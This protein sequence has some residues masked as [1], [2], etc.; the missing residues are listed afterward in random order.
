MKQIFKYITVF[1][2]SLTIVGC[3][4]KTELPS[5]YTSYVD[6]T[7][8]SDYHG[9]VFVGASVPFGMVQ[10]GPTNISKG[11]DWCSGYHRSDSVII[12]FA[13]THLSGTG[14]GDL[15]DIL[16]MPSPD[17]LSTQKA[18]YATTYS[19]DNQS[20]KP[21]YYSVAL[22]NG[23]DVELTSTNRVGMHRYQFPEGSQ[24]RLVFDLGEGIDWDAPTDTYIK[25]IDETTI[26]GHRFSTGWAKDQKIY[27]TASFSA[28]IKAFTPRK[29]WCYRPRTKD[30]I[31]V[32][33]AIVDFGSTAEL[34]AKVALSYVS[35]DNA[36]ENMSA[37]LPEW[38]FD[39]VVAAADE[40]WE[41]QLSKIDA[42]SS[43]PAV[44]RTFYTALY[45]TMISPVT[46]CDVNGDY[47]GADGKSYNTQEFTPYSIFSLWDT[48]RT[49]SPLSMILHPDKIEDYVNS[50]LAIYE[51]Q[52]KLPVW[53]LVGNETDCMVG[54]HSVPVIVDA[55]LKGYR[56]FDA[57]LAFE[58][59][60]SFAESDERGLKYV[61]EI[62]Y[63]PAEKEGWSVAKALEYAID[64]YAIAQ[65]ARALGRDDDYKRYTERSKYY[66]NYF[67][68]SVGFMRGK[69][70]NGEWNPKFDPF[71]SMHMEDDYVE[72]NAWQYT[73]LVPHDVQGLVSLFD[74]EESFTQKLDSL[75]TVSS[76][77][78]EGASVDITGLIGQ[79]AHGNEPSH[80]TLYLYP[81]V[82]QQWKSAP[83]L[84][85]V[86][87]EFY[88]DTP[89][90]IVGN[91]DCG[92]MSAWYIMSVMGI[93]PVNPVGGLYVFGSPL[94]QEARINLEGGKCFEMVAHDLSDDAI[95]IQSVRL[96]GEP[97]TKSYITHDDLMR[98]AKL[99]F[100]MGAEPNQSFASEVQ[101]RPLQQYL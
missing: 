48:Y 36:K 64:D 44:M 76:E 45:H 52:G 61:N 93:Y 46:F 47:R 50:F 91:E 62:G 99:E 59:M 70:S 94:L 90:G 51:Q 14:I 6:P 7:I 2:L 17:A 68:K 88:N 38:D 75:F 96:D 29:E 20:V 100:F 34:Q 12:G 41:E 92:Q 32:D 55:Y 63:I 80:A 5:D 82:G 60:K 98:G 97:Y 35:C 56:D 101:D 23:V 18:D 84:H 11:W 13:H 31:L 87:R 30:S 15:G 74:S 49:A 3:C 22:D 86:Y 25:Q 89:S 42:R 72:G 21:G 9:H 53:H 54:Y 57:E 58:A 95:Y 81:Y 4:D 10:L 8:G 67:D 37:E 71:Y 43:D 85:H 40:A 33:K 79:Y 69:L 39:G 65:M 77:L 83:K 24:S 27:F 19:L 16:V 1:A 26:Q 66:T 28:P 78:N 73:W